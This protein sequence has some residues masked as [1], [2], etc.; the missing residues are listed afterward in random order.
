MHDL[1]FET[2]TP[3]II[4]GMHRSG[5]GM[6]A[7]LLKELGLF[8][9]RRLQQ[10]YEALFF[11][12]LN[13]WLLRQSG[14]AWD[15]P[16]A[17]R[18]LLAN[19]KV[20][21]LA[22]D[23]VRYLI[24]SPRVVSYLGWMHYLRHHDPTRLPC[25]WGWKDP[26]NT[27]TLPLWLDLFPEAKVIHVYRHGLDVSESLRVRMRKS[28]ARAEI[29]HERLGKR[30]RLYWFHARR[31]GFTDSLR[32]A[33]SL[34][35]SFELWESYMQQARAHVQSLANQAIE[36]K[37][38]EFVA[39]P[40]AGLMRLAQFCGLHAT[41]ATIDRLVASVRESRAYAFRSNPEL[42]AYASEIDNRLAE[43]GYS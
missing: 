2:S 24:G 4:M 21:A 31:A 43:W 18:Y 35:A 25:S 39:D 29:G 20:R 36:I 10:D 32:C 27:Y 17:I 13:E 12:Q 23:Y 22:V 6:I 28:L 41:D 34:G 33:A 7:R 38:E 11:L 26:R 3:I 9:G 8:I 40:R 16:E 42:L 19:A 14:G 1:R 15:Q 30:L 37:Y 5:T